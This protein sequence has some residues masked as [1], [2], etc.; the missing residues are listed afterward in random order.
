VWRRFLCNCPQIRGGIFATL[1]QLLPHADSPS[2]TVT[3]SEVPGAPVHRDVGVSGPHGSKNHEGLGIE[4]KP[5]SRSR[6]GLPSTGL[7][8]ACAVALA[9]GSIGLTDEAY[10][11][12]GGDMA[13]YL[14]NGAFIR[15]LV[16]DWP[17]GRASQVVEY[18]R[19]YYARYPAI[20]LGHHPVLVPLL[21]AP[22]FA[23]L[24]ISVWAARLVPLASLLL[25]VVYL[26]ALMVRKYG[27]HAATLAAVLLATSPMIVTYT[28]LVMSEM[29]SIAL[30][31]ASAYYLFRFCE[32]GRRSA[33]ATCVV[34]FVLSLYAKPLAILVAPALVGSALIEAP[35]SRLMTRDVLLAV[36]AV[37]VLGAPAVALPLIVSSSNVHGVSEAVTLASKFTF[38]HLLRAAL[39]PQL[40]WPVLAAAAAAV[41]RAALRKDH[42]A[43]VFVLWIATVTPALYFFGGLDNEAYRY[44]LYWVP[45]FCALAASL[46]TG[47]RVRSIPVAIAVT[48]AASAIMQVATARTAVVAHISG[49]AGYEQ[50]A[51]FVLAANP[52]PTVLFS[53]DIDT[54]YFAFFVR[55]HDPSRRLVVLRSDKVF[56]TSLM[57]Q[58]NFEERIASRDQIYPVLHQLGTRYVVLEDRPSQSRVLEWLREEL[59][60]PRFAERL[61]L[62]I[63]SADPRLRGTS[64][65]VYE[66]LDHTPPDPN[67]VLSL[68]IPLVGQSLALPLRDLIERKLLR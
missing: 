43:L 32:S 34:A 53:G 62:P 47:W 22:L 27:Q 38:L 33:L 55:K 17:F 44:T 25:A 24:G 26:H 36:L 54:G 10:A 35:R 15:D 14:M 68:H 18:I 9:V 4:T 31:L 58:T 30:V 49:M 12:S 57:A 50:V 46:V 8:A 6:L 64:L 3:A 23:V 60:S 42:R 40:A 13:R 19:L 63:G 20:S 39:G 51:E 5:A 28:Q 2:L 7:I 21:E 59:N 48:L 67:A 66:L 41:G 37:V 61:R 29:P 11:A 56:T 65:A 52:G 1:V 45:A 16:A